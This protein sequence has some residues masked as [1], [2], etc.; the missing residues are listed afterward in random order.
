[1]KR[2]PLR[3]ALR[4]PSPRLALVAVSI[5]ATAS[6]KTQATTT[7]T[8]WQTMNDEENETLKGLISKYEAQNNAVKIDLQAL[9][10]STSARTSSAPRPRR[11]RRPTS[12][13][14]RS[15]TSPTGRR[16]AS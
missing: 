15:P 16:G 11:V 14:R 4:S 2:I 3:A 13:G 7:I 9:S 10:R 5:V 8:F 1:M 6:A 12:C